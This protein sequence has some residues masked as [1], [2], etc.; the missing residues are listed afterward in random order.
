MCTYFQI[1]STGNT[2]ERKLGLHAAAI[3]EREHGGERVPPRQAGQPAPRAR[4]RT[5]PRP[6]QLH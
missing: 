2:T 4:E 6:P 1:K 3:Q 5:H